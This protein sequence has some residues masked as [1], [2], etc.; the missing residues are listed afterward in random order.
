MTSGDVSNTC[1]LCEAVLGS[2]PE[3]TDRDA[4]RITCPR[5]GR[6]DLDGSFAVVLPRFAKEEP[7]RAAVM[8][9]VIRRAQV[10]SKPPFLDASLWE[11]TVANVQPP[12]PAEQAE[13]LILWLGST[14]R[15]PG[16]YAEIGM[17]HRAVVGALSD[18]N[19]M[20]LLDH[21]IKR[22]LLDGLL[23]S[24]GAAA[25]LSFEGW[26]AFEQL[27]RESP[28]QTRRA[29]M[30]MLYGDPL[31]D[32]V[33]LSCFK[34]AVARTGFELFRLDEEPQAGLIDDRLRLEIRRSRFLVADLTRGSNGAYWEAG[35][36]EGLGKPV[37]YTCERGEFQKRGT[38]F[39]TNHLH[40]V[41]WEEPDLQTAGDRL[42]L[43]IRTTLPDEAKLDD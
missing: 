27:Q 11:S 16:E 7:L 24:N 29:F 39:D 23:H 8:S 20:W 9:H 38:H 40:T 33:F 35:Y 15:A 4:E 37:I 1:P 10:G 6:Y 25:T 36:A 30:A 13:N 19:F 12:S 22:G 14:N 34:P 43:T 41:I 2:P 21:L 18:S 32:K 42:A 5:C 31:V 26:A 3:P 28:R 17:I